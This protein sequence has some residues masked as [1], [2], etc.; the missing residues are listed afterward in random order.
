MFSNMWIIFND[1]I[2]NGKYFSL[3]KFKKILVMKEEEVELNKD[4]N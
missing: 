3:L 2:K 1:F 4:E